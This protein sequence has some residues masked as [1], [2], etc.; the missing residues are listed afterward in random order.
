[1]LRISRSVREEESVEL[2]SDGVEIKVPGEDRDGGSSSDERS[3]DVGFRSE[4]EHGD[5]DVSV[6]IEGVGMRSA[7]LRNE[8]LDRRIP[9]FRPLRRDVVTFS[10]RELRQGRSVISEE[11]RDG[12]SIDSGDS[13]HTVTVT[14]LVKTLD[15][16]VVGVSLREISDDDSGALDS[17]TLKERWRSVE[18]AVGVVVRY[19]VVSDQRSGAGEQETTSEHHSGN[20]LDR[21]E[22]KRTTK[23]D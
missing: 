1:M 12:S 16:E 23:S 5:L 13:W 20:R 7:D 22:R 18:F 9:V 10:D 11:S 15:G 19:T 3:E 2:I 6:R 21:V 4:I 14:P 8:I 17:V